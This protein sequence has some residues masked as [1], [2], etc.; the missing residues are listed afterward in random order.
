MTD[1]DTSVPDADGVAPPGLTSLARAAAA[2]AAQAGQAAGSDRASPA[3]AARSAARAD[4]GPPRGGTNAPEGALEFEESTAV[5][6]VPHAHLP[7]AAARQMLDELL[8]LARAEAEA[9]AQP[10]RRQA[11][12]WR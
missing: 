6:P 2:E 8:G 1:G 3:M 5:A 10:E 9:A 4:D 11:L 7:E 12:T